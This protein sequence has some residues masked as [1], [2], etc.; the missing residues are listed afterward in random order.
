M[1]A[2]TARP[3][4]SSSITSSHFYHLTS[5]P[6]PLTLFLRINKHR[7]LKCYHSSP[8]MQLFQC[9][10]ALHP[11]LLH[12]TLTSC[13]QLSPASSV[14]TMLHWNSK[15]LADY[16]ETW[17]QEHRPDEQLIDIC[18]NPT[19][20][21]TIGFQTRCTVA[22]WQCHCSVA[23]YPLLSGWGTFW[24]NTFGAGLV[25]VCNK[26]RAACKASRTYPETWFL[27]YPVELLQFWQQ[28]QPEHRTSGS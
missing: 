11:P 19:K 27:S 9:P 22:L 7:N 14:C 23:S 2:G 17:I 15:A 8:Q 21:Q 6:F 13:S 5:S 1:W 10:A 18:N 26:V 28:H 24:L 4:A 16:H 3:P 25:S 12:G 20:N